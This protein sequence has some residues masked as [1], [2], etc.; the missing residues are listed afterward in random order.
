MKKQTINFTII[1]AILFLGCNNATVDKRQMVNQ[2]IGDISFESKFGYKPNEKTDNTLRIKTHLEYVEKLLRKKNISNLSNELKIKRNHLLDLLHIYWM[3]EKFPKNY[4]YA[5]QRK[6]CFIDKEGTI[7]ALGYLIEQ[8][9]SRQVADDINKIHKYDELLSMNNAIVDNWVCSSG[10]TKEECAMIQPTYAP[11]KG[12]LNYISPGYGIS[13]SIIAGVNLSIN[14][15]NGIQIA[16]DNTNRTIPKIGIVTGAVQVMLGSTMFLKKYN[17][18]NRVII[19]GNERA[20]SYMNIG[21]GATTSIFSA[22]NL[23]HNKKV[24]NNS[25]TFNIYSFPTPNNNVAFGLSMIQK[26]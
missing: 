26:L 4:D 13:S 8:T 5:D 14:V 19:R 3:N 24:K 6:P 2:I 17:P 23:I 20:L 7:C 16:K 15:L 10:L 25:T 22:I 12:P 1:I 18:T 21:L 11:T 9:T